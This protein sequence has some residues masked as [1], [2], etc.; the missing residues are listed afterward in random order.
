MFRRHQPRALRG[1]STP[2]RRKKGPA[3]RSLSWRRSSVERLEDRWMLSVNVPALHS[4]AGAATTIYLD[5]DGHNIRNTPWN[6]NGFDNLINLPFDTD[7]NLAD[8]GATELQTIQSVWERVSE[9]FR[10]FVGSPT[11]LGRAARRTL[12]VVGEP[13]G[14]RPID[15][16]GSRCGRA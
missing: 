10:P 12:Y 2:K 4:N 7:G 6:V 16:G 5:F 1:N 13:V 3:V 15:A 9:D 11:L 8:F 14:F